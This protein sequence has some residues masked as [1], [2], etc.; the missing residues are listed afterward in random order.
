MVKPFDPGAS[1]AAGQREARVTAQAALV[2]PLRVR[3]GAGILACISPFVLPKNT[4]FFR[5]F[6]VFAP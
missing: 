4:V 1:T 2:F 3:L 5:N 6:T